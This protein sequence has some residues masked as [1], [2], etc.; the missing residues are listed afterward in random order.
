MHKKPEF[1][2]GVILNCDVLQ[3]TESQHFD[4]DLSN[5]VLRA[6][7]GSNP[8]WIEDP[9]VLLARQKTISEGHKY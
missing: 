7:N 5:D 6:R 8:W 1:K 3:A 9:V 4:E 2:Q